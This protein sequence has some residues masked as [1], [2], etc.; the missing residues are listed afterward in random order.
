MDEPEET[1]IS[2][3]GIPQTLRQ[4]GARAHIGGI[5][6]IVLYVGAEVKVFLTDDQAENLISSIE[7]A[8]AELL[9][10]LREPN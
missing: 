2:S 6:L 8:R 3:V 10:N 7:M 9:Q 5:E 1:G 4:I